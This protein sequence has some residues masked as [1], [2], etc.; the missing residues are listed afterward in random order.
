MT[1][2]AHSREWQLGY[3]DAQAE[4]RAEVERL[5]AENERL[6]DLVRYK[7]SEL[8]SDGL[9]DEDEYA[10]L[11]VDGAKVSVMRLEGYDI[12]RA[13]LAILIAERDAAIQP[14]KDA[15]R[16]Y[17]DPAMWDVDTH[18]AKPARRGST[19]PKRIQRKCIRGWRMP[20]NAVYVGRPTKWGNLWTVGY[21]RCG[22]RSV[23][24]CSHNTFRCPTA[25]DAVIAFREW[26]MAGRFLR[27]DALKE[28]RGKDLACWCALDQPCH[29]D[30][31][32]EI[33]NSH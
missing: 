18:P 2:I 17:A 25:D 20:E 7:R 12:I 15:L 26:I 1:L 22:C 21:V 3:D 32:L 33:A 11:L 4:S 8:L 30:V 29:A 9:I 31:L 23:G 27:F 6:F 28:L 10:R 5:K 13:K 19:M 24:E 16:F 14:W